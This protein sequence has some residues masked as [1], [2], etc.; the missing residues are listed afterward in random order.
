MPLP[1]IV[2]QDMMME[3]ASYTGAIAGTKKGSARHSAK[4]SL[5]LSFRATRWPLETVSSYDPHRPRAMRIRANR[6]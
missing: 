6:Y 1:P 5:S 4:H 2:P 3:T